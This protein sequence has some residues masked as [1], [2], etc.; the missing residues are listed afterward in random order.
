MLC[1]R[2]LFTAE[3][4]ALSCLVA[5]ERPDLLGVETRR[6]RSRRDWDAKA[7]Q[8]GLTATRA[9]TAPESIWTRRLRTGE[10]GFAPF[11]TGSSITF[12]LNSTATRQGRSAAADQTPKGMAVARAIQQATLAKATP[13]ESGQGSAHSVDGAQA[14]ARAQAQVRGLEP[15]PGPGRTPGARWKARL[16]KCV[17]RVLPDPSSRSGR[18]SYSPRKT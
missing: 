5:Q 15:G 14:Q 18:R 3:V 2:N 17:L 8:T 1:R 9:A 7:L 13:A 16:R 11:C 6:G 4:S 10:R 12:A